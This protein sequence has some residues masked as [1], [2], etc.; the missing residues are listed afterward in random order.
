[1]MASGTREPDLFDYHD[2][3][4]AVIDSIPPN[5][6]EVV[7]AAWNLTPT[8]GIIDWVTEDPYPLD[9]TFKANPN[10]L[11]ER[12]WNI[13][14]ELSNAGSEDEYRAIQLREVERQD[15][16]ATVHE[17]GAAGIATAVA[18]DIFDPTMLPFLFVPFVGQASRLRN[19][20]KFGSVIGAEMGARELIAHHQ[21]PSR[22]YM[23]T[24]PIMLGTTAL[25]IALGAVMKPSLRNVPSELTDNMVKQQDKIF[26]SAVSDTLGES[27]GPFRA[28]G[29]TVATNYYGPR[30][31]SHEKVI[32]PKV[33]SALIVPNPRSRLA[34]SANKGGLAEPSAIGDELVRGHVPKARDEMGVSPLYP[35]GKTMPWEEEVTRQQ[36]LLA[37]FSGSSNNSVRNFIRDLTGK[38]PSYQAVDELTHRMYMYGDEVWI[39]PNLSKSI[40]GIENHLNDL[41]PFIDD[42]LAVKASVTA[43]QENVGMFGYVTEKVADDSG[44][45]KTVYKLDD[46]GNRIKVQAKDLPKYSP[47][48]AH[49][50]FD[51][52]KIRQNP[53]VW[54]AKVAH[55]YR[56][57]ERLTTLGLAE[58][59]TFDELYERGLDTWSNITSSAKMNPNDGG[60][61]IKHYGPPSMKPITMTVLRKDIDD[62]I[63][64]SMDAEFNA[65]AK[66]VEPILNGLE[67]YGDD[68]L[69]YTK[70]GDIEVPYLMDRMKAEYEN[71]R[72]P[73]AEVDSPRL[74][75]MEKVY[76]QSRI[77]VQHIV[78]KITGNDRRM[79]V[80]DSK[81][82]QVLNELRAYT[83]FAWLGN[84]AVASVHEVA[85]SQIF[86]GLGPVAKSMGVLINPTDLVKANI[87]QLRA[88]SMGLD[89]T[90]AKSTALM[91]ADVEDPVAAASN[92]GTF[93]QR[94]WEGKGS[95][96]TRNVDKV[97]KYTGMNYMLQ[98]F[99]DVE[100]L[101]FM[102]D[103]VNFAIKQN[104]PAAGSG[105]YKAAMRNFTRFGISK[106]DFERIAK[107]VSNGGI[108]QEKGVWLFNADKIKDGDLVDRIWSTV[109]S[110]GEVSVVKGGKGAIPIMMD[111][112]IGRSIV[113]F[114][115]VFFG[116]QGRMESLALSLSEGDLRAANGLITSFSMTW[117][118]WQL[119]MFMKHFANDPD[120][121]AEEFAKEWDASPIQDHI[122]QM[123]SRTGYTGLTL[124][125]LEQ[126]DKATKGGLSHAINTNVGNKFYKGDG[127]VVANM[128]PS[129]TWTEK[130]LSVVTAPLKEGGTTPRDVKNAASLG[131]MATVIYLDPILEAIARA[132]GETIE[133]PS[134]KAKSAAE[135]VDY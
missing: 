2:A 10:T 109:A 3:P 82:G 73:L 121:A 83:S 79:G 127:T 7:N 56:N 89:V 130:V 78:N 70:N 19:I 81:L 65:L 128:I 6:G 22:T 88:F 71:K 69:I 119:R 84:V 55:A 61:V 93:I 25:G 99:K 74:D 114:K 51:K 53:N 92:A 135:G 23:D 15:Y 33:S 14:E 26:K 101:S 8:K 102:T 77:D 123:I 21:Q 95:F 52:R 80:L 28:A 4:M 129:L 34:H 125:G 72:V 112:P 113:Q 12:F 37:A 17:G 49:T 29:S 41:K 47:N 110:A 36:G 60:N 126:V 111:N 85:R 54:A 75:K 63:I 40:P 100:A 96:A 118:A 87:D 18:L 32:A 122:Y 124:L 64:H 108:V 120:T 97:Y 39:P 50:F 58:S 104:V 62:Y 38:K 134:K 67:R 66:D 9:P 43:R 68:G 31:V 132:A 13:S 90:S 44:K 1:M 59:R 16:M 48:H 27:E 133:E 106:S 30:R 42:L 11:D 46:N 115:R 45:I 35:N 103:M 20:T 117:M 24:V 57:P 91:R 94:A 131:P 86:H 98:K 116:Y 76:A 107:E 105:A 5:Y